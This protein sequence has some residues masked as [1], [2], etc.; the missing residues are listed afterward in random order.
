MN[1]KCAFLRASAFVVFA[2]PAIAAFIPP[3]LPLVTPTQDS[4]GRFVINEGI[5]YQLPFPLAFE[6]G[7]VIL[8]EPQGLPS[9]LA[10]FF[11]NLQDFGNGT[12]IGNL[13]FMYSDI[14]LMPDSGDNF[15]I[16]TDR[17]FNVVTLSELGPENGVQ[18]TPYTA[19]LLDGSSISYLL[20]SDVPE[21]SSMLLI[22]SGLL[23]LATVC[24]KR[25]FTKV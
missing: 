25:S 20:V 19:S 4:Q 21:P 23:V 16:L 6:S 18:G 9:D 1:P 22:G 2:L 10:R 14:D 5:L 3:D 12:G 24:R 8:A 7:D 15:P 17:M 13:I 11:N